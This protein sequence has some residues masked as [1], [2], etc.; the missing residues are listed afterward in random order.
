MSNEKISS[1]SYDLNKWLYGGYEPE[2]IT[3]IAGPP[4][5]GKTNMVLLAACSQAKKGKKVI[6]I[7][8]E[9]GFSVERVKQ[10]VSSDFEK[11]LENILILNPTNFEEQKKAFSKLLALVSKENIGLIVVD[12]MAILYRL[13]IGDAHE[14]KDDRKIQEIN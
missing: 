1:G 4:A 12:S 5:S 9:G 2:V 6:F 7:D 10:I 11:I 14:A 13:E 8:T 3:M